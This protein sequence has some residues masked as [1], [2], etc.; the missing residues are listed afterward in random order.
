[1]NKG[2][3]GLLKLDFLNLYK[4]KEYSG[5]TLIALVITIIVMLILA[6]VSLNAVIGENGIIT[7]AQK[8]TY[9]QGIVALEEY[10]Q[11]EYVK[12]YNEAENY[13]S[14][15]ELLASKMNNLCLKDGT[16]NYI[17]Y[18]GKMYYLLNKEG[19]PNELKNQLR[20]GDTTEREKYIRLIDVYGITSDLKVYYCENGTDTVLGTIEDKNVDPNIPV[21]KLNN[22]VE[23][24]KAITEALAEQ[25]IIVGEEGI[26]TGNVASIKE[27]ELDGSKYNIKSL[28]ALSELNAL[29]KLELKDINVSNLEGVDG[30]P[31]LQYIFFENC[32]IEN[33]EHIIK[34]LGL[35]YLYEYLPPERSEEECNREIENLSIAMEKADNLNKLEYVGIY[36]YDYVRNGYGV[37]VSG[38]DIMTPSW[39]ECL[40]KSKLSNITVLSKW[41]E[42]VKNSI[43]YMYLNNNSISSIE[44]LEGYKNI[45][46]L[47]ILGNT[48]L[49]N[50]NG[51]ENH[52]NLRYIAAQRCSLNN[53]SGLEDSRNLYYVTFSFNS[54]LTSLTGIENSTM[55]KLVA[56]NCNFED[57]SAIETTKNTLEYLDIRNNTN[58]QNVEAISKCTKLNNL[59]LEN[60][61]NM[62][63]ADVMKL[64]GIIANC[65]TNY[66]LPSKY[67]ILFSNLSSY[68]YT[69]LGLV[70][71]SREITALKNKTNIEWLRLYGNTNLG[72]SRIA[73]L[74]KE[75]YLEIEELDKIKENLDLTE[76]EISYIDSLKSRGKANVESM[77]DSEIE[78]G[79]KENDIYIR[80]VLSTLTGLRKLSIGNISNITSIDFLNKV[81]N[82]SELDLRGTNITDLSKLETKALRLG[83]LAVDNIEI[84]FSKIQGT[85][86]R[87]YDNYRNDSDTKSVWANQNYNEIFY[88]GL[89]LFNN[90][91]TDA[92]KNCANVTKLKISYN[93]GRNGQKLDLSNCINLN[94]LDYSY[95]IFATPAKNMDYV[96]CYYGILDCSA[97]FY[98]R[99]LVFGANSIV[100]DSFQYMKNIQ[101][102][103]LSIG[104]LSIP[105]L[106][107]LDTLEGCKNTLKSLS[108]R[109][110]FSAY[111]YRPQTGS[112]G[113][114]EDF[115]NLEKIILAGSRNSEILEGASKLKAVK[116]LNVR[117][118]NIPDISE[119][120]SLIT[121]RQLYLSDNKISNAESLSNLTNL[122][123]LEL[124]NNSITD[125]Y[126]LRSLVQT[127]RTSITNLDLRNNLLENYNGS[128]QDN[129]EILKMFKDAGTQIVYSGNN[130]SD[131]SILE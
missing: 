101:I 42:T 26:T 119:L 29:Q 40:E 98:I 51:L 5:I 97:T 109:D 103:E 93:E 16:R 95:G 38:K 85:L 68:D 71:T 12:Y 115:T 44:S 122:Q 60:N 112:L 54:N 110:T 130:F 91:F 45:Y 23:M 70:D 87:I 8:A 43:K 96:R 27:L 46:E 65:G 48:N 129:V 15:V 80:Y 90:N 25:G 116:T 126:P 63:D 107:L 55:Y 117:S 123:T 28:S 111:Y 7:Q 14:K 74:I 21:Q 72:K 9:M 56:N 69:S 84:D 89:F 100:Q 58:L 92:F 66:S 53:I 106:N 99:N 52:T 88:A 124:S 19:L 102:E 131:T 41:S 113:A 13:T 34:V 36:G 120:S 18:N 31:V 118:N 114:L 22:D 17:I 73:K 127:G 3:N 78:A 32:K 1:M 81:T 4:T 104:Q 64:E 37:G 125:I 128:G 2:K 121:L 59:Y 20:G 67:S 24:K 105:D 33:Y 79:E 77:S 6:G 39:T 75:G 83:T 86:D 47:W 35:K 11:T 108:A 62:L 76:D 10:L 50:L 49:V 30:C 94:K 57:I 61:N 82:L